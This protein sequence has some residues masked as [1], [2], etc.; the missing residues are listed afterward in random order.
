MEVAS[1]VFGSILLLFML[2]VLF[3]GPKEPSSY[4]HRQLAFLNALLAG[5]FGFFLSGAVT[6]EVTAQLGSGLKVAINATAGMA[7]FVI[8]LFWWF[9]KWAASKSP[10]TAP[11]QEG[12]SAPT[13]ST[14]RIKPPTRIVVPEDKINKDPEV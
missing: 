12:M 10:R 13:T 8:V 11:S 4:Q 5:L 3:W 2:C 6:A 9:S 7:L 1:W 14:S